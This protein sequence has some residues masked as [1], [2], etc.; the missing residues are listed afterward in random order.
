MAKILIVDDESRIRRS[1]REIL[2]Y[3]KYDIDE[4][5]DGLECIEKIKAGSYDAVLMDIR[6]PRMDGIEALSKLLEINSD[7][8]IIMIS[9]N[10]DIDTAVS[11]VRKGA[12][13]FICK[14]PDI[15]RLLIT[16]RNAL[17]KN[18]LIVDKKELAW[19]ASKYKTPEIVGES[20]PVMKVKSIIQTV[21]P[22][23]N[24]R[25]M[26]TGPN[27]CGKELVARWIHELSPRAKKPLV[28]VNCAAIPSELIESELFG[29]KKGSF[30]G[31]FADRIGKFEE[32]SGGTLFLDEIGDM[33]L[34]AQAKV[35]RALE[36]GRI[37]RIGENKDIKVDVRVLAATNKDLQKQI[38]LGNFRQDLY[39]RLAVVPVYVPPLRERSG[40]IPM[41]VQHYIDVICE[42]EGIPTFS[43]QPA[44][45]QILQGLPWHGNIRELRNVIERLSIFCQNEVTE[46]DIYTYVT[47]FS[48]ES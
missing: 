41:L 14:P 43:I 34:D 4:A 5:E 46:E 45:L 27:G 38:E 16:V 25:V 3:E 48:M 29:H 18:S 40:D 17:D 35:L 33:S 15:H 7:L 30:T 1:L 9:A 28:E 26:I 8:P 2:E 6:M 36:S 11:T 31:A 19:K 42:A 23:T 10:S 32:A 22:H 47:P 21:A 20:E 39:Y 24:T 13:D 44:A 12:Y 37:T